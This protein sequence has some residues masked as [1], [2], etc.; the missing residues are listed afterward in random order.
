[1][2]E[3]LQT[4]RARRSIRNFKP[5]LPPQELIDRVI[6][7]G[8]C[9][10]SG[11]G[12]QSSIIIAVTNPELR[13]QLADLNRRAANWDEGIDPFYGAPVV[14]SVL[15][16]PSVPTWVNDGSLTL[17]NMLTAAQSLGLGNIWV[18]RAKE[19]FESARGRAIL[20]D[21][22]VEGEYVGVGHCVLG[23]AGAE[24]PAAPARRP[25][26]VFRAD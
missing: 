21:L 11:M 14:L 8:L 1:M 9:A 12:K 2:N 16:D 7:A 20:K 4:I 25:G 18:H 23:Y 17:G 13:A 5:D 24:P 15:A 26:R 6:E 3:T 22:G 10:P 19:V